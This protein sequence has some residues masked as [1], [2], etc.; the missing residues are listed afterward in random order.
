MRPALEFERALPLKIFSFLSDAES[1]DRSPEEW[2]RLATDLYASVD[3]FEGP[4]SQAEW[5]GAAMVL[6][7]YPRAKRELIAMGFSPD[8][9]EDMAVWQVIA[10]H[11]ARILRHVAHEM[12]KWSLLPPHEGLPGLQS[13][14]AALRR[15][16]YLGNM[17][18]SKEIVPIGGKFLPALDAAMFASA[19]VEREFAVLRVVE[20]L[21]MHTA[22]SGRLPKSLAE[23]SLAPVP[24]DPVTGK[25]FQYRVDGATAVIEAPA[26]EAGRF[27]GA[28]YEVTLEA[29]P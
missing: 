7:G 22:R 18:N 16:G 8:K 2:R 11:E 1:V 27:R 24:S 14:I 6:R 28:R 15:D 19:R 21:R 12:F 3:D 4:R 17:L 9:V 13:S 29:R 26:L 5:L 20:A 25:P 23:V 10:I